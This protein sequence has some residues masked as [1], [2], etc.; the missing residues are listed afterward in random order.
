MKRLIFLLFIIL[1]YSFEMFSQEDDVKNLA[2]TSFKVSSGLN[3]DN[4]RHIIQ[5]SLG[6]I[7]VGTANELYRFDGHST[8]PI[9]L[10]E[11]M[12]SMFYIEHLFK[13][14]YGNIWIVTSKGT[15]IF[16]FNSQKIISPPLELDEYSI[17][18]FF[19]GEGEDIWFST[20]DGEILYYNPGNKKLISYPSSHRSPITTIVSFSNNELV[21]SFENSQFETFNMDN[22]AFISDLDVDNLNLG[23]N[24]VYTAAKYEN[25]KVVLASRKRLFQLG[26]DK[27]LTELELDTKTIKN[28]Q[29]LFISD[30]LVVNDSIVWIATDG[31]GLL[32]YNLNSK[33]TQ[34]LNLKSEFPIYA[35]SSLYKD[36]NGIIWIGTTNSG[37]KVFDPYQSKFTHWEYEKG[38]PTGLS[39]NSVLCLNET[40]DGKILVG[41]DGGG[42]NIYNHSSNLFKHYVHSQNDKNVINSIISDHNNNIW[43]G[44][45]LNGLNLFQDKN[46]DFT[47]IDHPLSMDAKPN[48]IIKSFHIDSHKNLWIGTSNGVY[49]HDPNGNFIR[50]INK[51]DDKDPKDLGLVMCVYEMADSTIWI[52]TNNL[53]AR[54]RPSQDITETVNIDDANLIVTSII[55]V[56]DMIWIG[57]K[58]G[59][60]LY[61]L[62]NGKIRQYTEE[63]GLSCTVVNGLLSDDLGNLWI[64][65]TQGLFQYNFQKDEFRDFGFN[66]GFEG[67]FNENATLKGRDGKLYFG[68]TKG[69]HSFFPNQIKK[70]NKVPPVIIS[71]LSIYNQNKSNQDSINTI[72][73]RNL[74]NQNEIELAYDQNIFS[75]DFVGINFTLANNNQ[76]RYILHGFDKFWNNTDGQ[77]QATYTNIPPG[78]YEFQVMASNN[79]GVWNNEGKILNINILPPWYK[80]TWAIGLWIIIAI[81]SIFF[82]N[83]YIWSQIKLKEIL[84]TERLDKLRQEEA[85]ENKIQ[86]FTNITH[87]LRTPLTLIL[88]PIDKL[89]SNTKVDLAQRK[90]LHLIKKNTNRLLILINQILDFRKLELGEIK[91]NVS[92]I[93]LVLFMGDICDSFKEMA[94]EKSISIQYT[95]HIDNLDIWSDSGTIEKIMFNLL[96]NAIKFSSENDEIEVDVSLDKITSEAVIDIMDMGKGIPNEE[97]SNIFKRFYQVKSNTNT[98][99]GIGLALTHDMVK[100]IKGTIQ[101]KSKLGFGSTF[102]VRLPLGNDH[103]GLEGSDSYFSNEDIEYKP[104]P[105]IMEQSGKPYLEREQLEL[106]S[107]KYSVLV[108]EDEKDLRE[109]IVDSLKEFF[110]VWEAPNGEDGYKMAIDLNPNLIISDIL[111]PKLSGLELCQH[112]KSNFSTS[113]I[114]IILLTAL[115]SNNQIIE[116]IGKGADEYITKPFNSELLL[117]KVHNLIKNR[118]NLITRFKTEIAMEPEAIASTSADE[119][120]L[121]QVIEIIKDNISDSTFKVEHIINEIAMS[122]TPFYKKL[123]NLSGLSPN[124]FIRTIRMKH[125]VQLLT[126]SDKNI[127]E[128]AYEVGFSS[129]KYFRLC[130]KEQFGLTPS[131]YGKTPKNNF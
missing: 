20:R 119:Q 114:P 65:T 41:L 49:V 29:A 105:K 101:V 115:T 22:R 18:S 95:P 70:N 84:R 36:S 63:D 117:H 83:R 64:A 44:T 92:K 106:D 66:D 9:A 99:T 118:I 42:I 50:H 61:E 45:Y 124:D 55:E 120:F 121:K 107:N 33:K 43:V 109:Y 75:I 73:S 97:L 25:E 123:K 7:W 88:G 31:H 82:L 81:L 52:G 93:N 80:T 32:S 131:E 24:P 85:N 28:K 104:V 17:S 74:I 103:F 1:P 68:S 62:P 54:Y 5:D 102:S 59:L 48:E 126:N 47:L 23:N 56:D 26:I 129:P 87:E 96:A 91:I 57:T 38:N 15:K 37:I 116:G 130:F 128:I 86:F 19:Q 71:N 79:D 110:E 108:I 90:Q 12:S 14:N 111:M 98:G 4:V 30:L 67:Q 100:M 127:S 58:S 69:V 11:E 8:Y 10:F 113:H 40:L 39:S 77:R 2:I 89:I 35:I 72:D 78:K 51:T 6:Y 13:D 3:S 34:S 94:N 21:V 16:E 125:A 46:S 27:R 112:L 53:M 76:Y 60:Y 122:R